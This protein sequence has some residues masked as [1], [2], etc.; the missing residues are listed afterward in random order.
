MA[1]IYGDSMIRLSATAFGDT[2]DGVFFD[3]PKKFILRKTQVPNE[4]CIGGNAYFSF[5][6]PHSDDWQ[7]VDAQWVDYPLLNPCLGLQEQF[8]SGRILHF[9]KT[10]FTWE[11]METS[12]CRCILDRVHSLVYYSPSLP[13]KWFSRN[14]RTYVENSTFLRRFAKK[15]YSDMACSPSKYDLTEK[16]NGILREYCSLDMTFHKEK[17]PA[18]P[19]VA[20]LMQIWER[21]MF[22]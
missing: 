11:C 18:L 10:E 17:L 20:K 15:W 13:S 19:G 1:A 16:W 9:T 7:R 6:L 2:N 21:K 12:T 4:Y 22:I 3:L 5:S 14:S 8:L